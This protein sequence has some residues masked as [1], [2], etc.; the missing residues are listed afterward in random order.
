MRLLNLVLVFMLNFN[1]KYLTFETID[2]TLDTLFWFWR[3]LLNKNDKKYVHI[4]LLLVFL[5]SPYK[6]GNLTILALQ[7]AYK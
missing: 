1:R 6:W 3:N 2:D 4:R 5:E 7:Y